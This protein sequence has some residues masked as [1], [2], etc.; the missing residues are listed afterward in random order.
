MPDYSKGKI[1]K[2]VCNETGL[3]YI[4]STTETLKERL[5]CHKS[6]LNCSSKEIIQNNNYYIE[7]IEAVNA[8]NEIEL[9]KHE[10]FWIENSECVNQKIPLRTQK[11]FYEQNKEK[12]N[13][14]Q[15]EY[16]EKNKEKIKE[17][18]KEY[19]EQNKEKIKERKKEF[20]EQNKEKINQQQKERRKQKKLQMTSSS[21]L[22]TIS[23]KLL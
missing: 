13:Q 3:T 14:Q 19:Y 21:P 12:I 1:Y 11:E 22:T 16:R 5:N 9:K 23:S 15:Q 2:I 17:R 18:K 8:S 10:K 7:L 4:G 6:H 20:Y